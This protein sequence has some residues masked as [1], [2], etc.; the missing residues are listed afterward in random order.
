M[1]SSLRST[2]ARSAQH[3]VD[4]LARLGEIGERHVGADEQVEERVG[5]RLLGLAAH[6]GARSLAHVDEP[7]RRQ[8]AHRIAHDR[9]AD[10]EHLDQLG[11]RRDAVPGGPGAGQ[12]A[13]REHARDLVGERSRA[14]E[15][16]QGGP[17]RC[18]RIPAGV[19]SSASIG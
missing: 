15:E 6:D 4:R 13:L 12:H 2:A 7:A 5:V 9:A 1:S 16:R 14:A 3:Q 19:V 8:R 11:L 10:A 18:H 17:V